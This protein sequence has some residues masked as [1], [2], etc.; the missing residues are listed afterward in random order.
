[1]RFVGMMLPGNGAPVVGSVMMIERP[2]VLA[3]LGEVAAALQPAVG[4][5]LFCVPPGTNWPVYSC[6]QKK[7]SFFF[8]R[9][10][11]LRD[12]D[13]SADASKSRR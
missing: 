7:N 12:E 11:H 10:E 9:V 1:M 4:V 5:Y 3:A 13:R 2:V 6:D 8:S